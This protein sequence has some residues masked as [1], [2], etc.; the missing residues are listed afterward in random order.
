MKKIFIVLFV[1]I[2]LL[3]L[4]G[5]NKVERK[6]PEGWALKY[7]IEDAYDETIIAY[8]IEKYKVTNAFEDREG[9]EGTFV[10]YQI[11]LLNDSGKSIYYNIF[12]VFNRQIESTFFTRRTISEDEIIDVDLNYA[13]K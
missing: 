1:I 2:G 10:M 5:C 13:Q 11:T 12:I 3:I 9:G 8:T 6:T 7:A 4:S